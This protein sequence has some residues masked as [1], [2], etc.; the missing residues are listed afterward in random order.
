MKNPAAGYDPLIGVPIPGWPKEV[1]L[2]GWPAEPLWDQIADGDVHKASSRDLEAEHDVAPGDGGTVCRLEAGVD[3]DKAIIGISVGGLK[4]VCASFPARLPRSNWGPMFNAITLT[5]T[6]AMQLW[7]RRDMD[8][9]GAVSAGRTL[10]GADQPYSTWGDM[11]HLLSRETWNASAKY[12]ICASV[13]SSTR[14][15]ACR[16]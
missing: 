4:E 2:E 3:F 5:R 12:E 7:M 8:D 13:S 6:C 16:R 14:S 9:L 11:T 15:A 10:T 1:P